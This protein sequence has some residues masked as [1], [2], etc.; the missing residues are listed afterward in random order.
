MDKSG[1]YMHGNSIN[2]LQHGMRLDSLKG[3]AADALFEAYMI[4]DHLYHM[5]MILN[6][7]VEEL[8]ANLKGE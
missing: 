6:R 8:E 1:F 4:I 5:V 3:N 7:Q 2:A